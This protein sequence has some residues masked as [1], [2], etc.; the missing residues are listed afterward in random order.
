MF[1]ADYGL[2][3]SGLARLIRVTYDLL[4]LISFFT[5]GDE[6]CRAWTTR[7]GTN[8]LRAAGIVHSDFE[9]C[10]IR[11]E[12]IPCDV[13]LELKSLHSARERGLLKLEGKDYIVRDGDVITVR[14]SA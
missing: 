3:E 13:L 4:G 12:V 11:A 1:L 6:E 2:K 8:A 9:R 5:I 10:F 14:H 7:K